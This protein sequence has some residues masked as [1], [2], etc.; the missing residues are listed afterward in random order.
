MM[1]S[2]AM[3]VDDAAPILPGP[4]RADRNVPLASKGRFTGHIVAG[5]GAGRIIQTESHLEFDWCL[6]LLARQETAELREQVA[7]EWSDSDGR[8]HQHF[9][10]F[11][12]VQIDQRSIAYTVK[13]TKRI[14]QKFL[15]EMGIISEQAVSCGF[16]SDVR[17]LS[18][19]DLDPVAVFNARLFHGMRVPDPEADAIAG[20]VVGRMSG[21]ASLIQLTSRT[22]IGPRGFR[23]LIRLMA[24]HVL[25]PVRRG[26]IS[27]RTEVFKRKDAP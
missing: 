15:D 18:E 7:F 17:L 10:D 19:K 11:L 1:N 13:P 20:D 2:L 23:A 14:S 5:P 6:C 21:T 8:I 27:P 9:F 12:T 25:V 22:E 26:R 24:N 3:A 4:S 16:V